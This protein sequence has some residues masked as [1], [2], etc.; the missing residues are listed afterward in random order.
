LLVTWCR[1]LPT[2]PDGVCCVF[3]PED[4]EGEVEDAF[5]GFALRATVVDAL[6]LATS[7]VTSVLG[8][9]VLGIELMVPD[10]P[11]NKPMRLSE[12][13]ARCVSLSA[14]SDNAAG[15]SFEKSS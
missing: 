10:V 9:K 4:E 15:L 14:S 8:G 1:R 13:Y 3:A 11:V 2:C 7:G 12:V 5:P 6:L